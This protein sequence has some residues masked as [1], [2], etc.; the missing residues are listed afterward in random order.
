MSRTRVQGRFAKQSPGFL[1]ITALQPPPQPPKR[2]PLP[3]PAQGQDV[4]LKVEPAAL[5]QAVAQQA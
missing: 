5:L 2:R 1:S 3:A 4:A